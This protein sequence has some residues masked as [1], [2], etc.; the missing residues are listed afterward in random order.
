MRSN[1]ENRDDDKDEI[2]QNRISKYNKETEPLSEFYREESHLI[3]HEI[4]GN[5][6]IEKIQDDI[7]KILKK[8]RFTA[9]IH[10]I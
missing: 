9:I 10:H 3:Y 7:L 2:I 5:Q 8:W 1:I 4:N 6:E